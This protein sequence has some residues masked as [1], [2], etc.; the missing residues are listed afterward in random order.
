MKKNTLDDRDNVDLFIGVDD[1]NVI[2]LKEPED[3]F[4]LEIFKSLPLMRR[5]WIRLKVAFILTIRS[6]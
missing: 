2:E 5:I 4:Q 1:P 6:L 3:L